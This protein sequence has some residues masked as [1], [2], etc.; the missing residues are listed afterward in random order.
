MAEPVKKKRTTQKGK[1]TKS[2]RRLAESIEDKHPLDDVQKL[3]QVVISTADELEDLHLAYLEA[4]DTE[5]KTDDT[6]D[7]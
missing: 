3:L 6:A 1:L 2:L 5:G 4:L 7:T